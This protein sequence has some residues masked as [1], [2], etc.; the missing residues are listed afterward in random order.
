MQAAGYRELVAHVRGE[1]TLTEAV[2][3]IKARTRQLARR[4]L[5]WFRREPDLNWIEIEQ[6]ERPETTAQRIFKKL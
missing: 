6:D 1:L 3:L 2:R 4:Q 5:T